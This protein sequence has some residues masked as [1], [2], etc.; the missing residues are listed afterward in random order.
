MINSSPKTRS[1]SLNRFIVGDM[2]SHSILEMVD[3]VTPA[4]VAN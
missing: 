3:R 4:R 1:S 2:R